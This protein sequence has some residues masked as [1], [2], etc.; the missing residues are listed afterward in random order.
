M[1]PNILLRKVCCKQNKVKNLLLGLQN[2][3]QFNSYTVLVTHPC[4]NIPV[5]TST[6]STP[7]MTKRGSTTL[8]VKS[9]SLILTRNVLLCNF[10]P[11]VLVRGFVAV[12]K[13]PKQASFQRPKTSNPYPL[14][15][16]GLLSHS[17][18]F[19]LIFPSS[20]S[21]NSEFI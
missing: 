14:P 21:S 8:T 10:Y 16:T 20:P 12:Q 9:V 7:P 4:N 11:L 17:Y 3:H 1:V 18:G 15:P 13:E 5:P 19:Y 6:P 2:L